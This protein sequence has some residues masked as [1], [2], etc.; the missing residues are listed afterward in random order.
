MAAFEPNIDERDGLDPNPLSAFSIALAFSKDKDTMQKYTERFKNENIEIYS[1]TFLQ[2][3]ILFSGAILE[4]T[5]VYQDKERFKEYNKYRNDIE[6]DLYFSENI[7]RISVAVLKDLANLVVYKEKNKGFDML[8]YVKEA[9]QY[10]RAYVYALYHE[11]I[12]S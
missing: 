12:N 10:C 9:F 6:Q 3:T 2:N 11:Y 8:D 1:Q 4:A 5:L 7:M